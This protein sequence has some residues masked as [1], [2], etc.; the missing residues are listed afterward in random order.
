MQYQSEQTF[1]IQHIDT[2]EN[3]TTLKN[4][5][6]N[7]E[8]DC[9]FFLTDQSAKIEDTKMTPKIVD[10]E[11]KRYQIMETAVRVFLVIKIYHSVYPFLDR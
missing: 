2:G 4:L 9:I 10:K 8:I 7:P 11:E 5:L 1:F 6:I 3:K